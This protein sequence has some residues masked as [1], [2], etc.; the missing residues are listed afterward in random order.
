M[1]HRRPFRRPAHVH[2]RT[3][4]QS[5]TSTFT[6]AFDGWV[7]ETGTWS[8]ASNYLTNTSTGVQGK[9]RRD[10]TNGDFQMKFSYRDTSATRGPWAQVRFRHAD[11]NNYP[12]LTL[13]PVPLPYPSGGPGRL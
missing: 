1:Q 11:S 13:T 9:M 5:F 7:A 8:A 3:A 10:T 6:G 12:Y 2:A 4:N